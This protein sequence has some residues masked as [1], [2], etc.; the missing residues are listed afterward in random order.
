MKFLKLKQP[1]EKFFLYTT[2]SLAFLGLCGLILFQFS[3]PEFIGQYFTK[4]GSI[5]QDKISLLGQLRTESL[6]RGK[7]LLSL[8]FVALLLF[9]FSQLSPSFLKKIDPSQGV[10]GEICFGSSEKEN[11]TLAPKKILLLL[12]IVLLLGVGFRLFIGSQKAYYHLDETFSLEFINGIDIGSLSQ[13]V[14]TE[15]AKILTGDEIRE[16]VTISKWERFNFNHFFPILRS[17][18]HPPLYYWALHVFQVLLAGGEYSKWP[19]IILN[20]ILYLFSSIVLF[21]LS[22]RIFKDDLIALFPVI[23][24]S[25]S[26]LGV[27]VS[28]LLRMYEMLT[29][30][31]LLTLFF[32]VKIFQGSRHPR[33]WYA[34]FFSLLFGF[35]T[36]YYFL[37]FFFWLFVT[38]SLLLWREKRVL[39]Y[40]VIVSLGAGLVALLVNPSMFTNLTTGHRGPEALEKALDLF[41]YIKT[42][43]LVGQKLDFSLFAQGSLLILLTLLFILKSISFK[44]FSFPRVLYL[45]AVPLFMTFLVVAKVAPFSALRYYYN[46]VPI[47]L[48]LNLFFFTSLLQD[49]RR[50][51]YTFLFLFL[52]LSPRWIG[53]GRIDRGMVDFNLGSTS[54]FLNQK[55]NKV[56]QFLRNENSSVLVVLPQYGWGTDEIVPLL[57]NK[58]RVMFVK[59]GSTP[60]V[61]YSV[62]EESRDWSDFFIITSNDEKEL[63]EFEWLGIPLSRYTQT[64]VLGIAK[65]F[66]IEKEE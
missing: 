60:E 28:N 15:S 14:T 2:L 61:L 1:Y 50:G 49:W 19:G 53:E 48:I 56:G 46:L 31:T 64:G 32:S 6:V 23:L 9:L 21:R 12:S 30:A 7:I 4:D 10:L 42:W 34:L 26:P 43:I 27:G 65:I 37:L 11:T 51:K 18:P 16:I 13:G 40:Y 54:L 66:H 52:L 29:L 45:L 38:T 20:T 5:A 55:E 35:L 3:T 59:E 17:D 57:A 36:Q 44:K 62:A 58:E 39:R 63:S 22:Q 47:L 41:G 8:S 24:F 33:E 25:I